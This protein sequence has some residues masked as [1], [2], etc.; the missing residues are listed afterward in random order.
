MTDTTNPAADEPGS[1]PLRRRVADRWNSLNIAG[2]ALVVGGVVITVVGGLILLAHAA[3]PDHDDFE[4]NDDGF[5]Y[6]TNSIAPAPSHQYVGHGDFTY[7]KCSHEACIKKM[8]PRITGHDCCGRC[9][10][11]KIRDCH[12]ATQRDYDGPGGFPHDYYE[13]LLFPGVCVVCDGPPERHLILDGACT[14]PL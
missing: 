11:S 10:T 5:A 1:S 13:G 8:D 6:D 12:G 3:S 9:R 7:P 2:K 14:R 4:P